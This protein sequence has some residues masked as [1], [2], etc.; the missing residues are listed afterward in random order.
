MVRISLNGAVRAV[1]VFFLVT[2]GFAQSAQSH[3]VPY[4]EDGFGFHSFSPIYLDYPGTYE[5]IKDVDFRN[6]SLHFS[7]DPKKLGPI[8]RLKNG[9]Y[10]KADP[11]VD[12]CMDEVKLEETHYLPSSEPDRQYALGIYSWF[13]ACGS[14]DTTGIAQVFE[15][16][17]HRLKVVQQLDWDQ[18]FDTKQEYFSYDKR[19]KA[20]VVRSAHYVLWKDGP[21]DAH[22]CASAM[23][24]ITLR[25]NGARMVRTAMRTELSEYGLREGKNLD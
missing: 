24:V 2:L 3:K 25:W 20:L 8:A 19:S 11:K 12:Q 23:D 9:H 7:Y 4:T 10:L 22:C 14:S 21:G 17:D 15:L 16:Y 18:H 1:L 5:H 6:L 13:T